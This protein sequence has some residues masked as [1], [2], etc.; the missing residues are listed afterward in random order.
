MNLQEHF[1]SHAGN[2]DR[3]T[4]GLSMVGLFWSVPLCA[5]IFPPAAL[6]LPVSFYAMA[7]LTV[8][9]L[10]DIG[11]SGK[12]IFL[13]LVAVVIYIAALL[14]SGVVAFGSGMEEA[15]AHAQAWASAVGGWLAVCVFLAGAALIVMPSTAHSRAKFGRPGLPLIAPPLPQ[16]RKVAG[17]LREAWPKA[18][19]SVHSLGQSLRSAS[20]DFA[21]VNWLKLFL[22]PTGRISRGAY[23][24]CFAL[25][26]F[27]CVLLFSL[28]GIVPVFNWTSVIVFFYGATCLA[29]KRLHDCGQSGWWAS[30][31]F[32]VFYA[33]I[34]LEF[35]LF[36]STLG[37][38]GPEMRTHAGIRQL[39]RATDDTFGH[40]LLASLIAYAV[41]ALV[42]GQRGENRFGAPL[43]EPSEDFDA[44]PLA[45]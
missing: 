39:D 31:P 17:S 2:I 12:W 6:L 34:V 40:I 9:R 14:L 30:M 41:L 32:V 3:R 33:Y 43:S 44:P 11:L 37:L 24:A 45:A 4:Y 36:L 8:K 35:C 38:F 22:W 16:V 1:F 7:C 5:A 18:A 13:P 23:I 10:H 21:R 15:G 25:V 26:L 42:P 20:A 27:V 29:S 28:L 19:S